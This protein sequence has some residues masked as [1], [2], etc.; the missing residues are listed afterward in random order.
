[1]GDGKVRPSRDRFRR[2]AIPL[3][4]IAQVRELTQGK[5]SRSSY[6][7]PS[8]SSLQVSPYAKAVAR[9]FLAGHKVRLRPVLP[10]RYQA[11][12]SPKRSASEI[13]MH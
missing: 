10:P 13:P 7:R 6:Y 2:I 5:L 4:M 8:R 12:K 1:M 9:A 3:A 11:R